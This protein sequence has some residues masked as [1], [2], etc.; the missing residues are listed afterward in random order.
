MKKMV[1]HNNKEYTDFVRSKLTLK[2]DYLLV[3]KKVI[4]EYRITHLR[5]IFLYFKINFYNV[6][7]LFIVNNYKN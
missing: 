7:F 5:D 4:G 1:L 2:C 6:L 3:Y